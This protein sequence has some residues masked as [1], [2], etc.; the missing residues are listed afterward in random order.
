MTNLHNSS[1]RLLVLLALLN[2]NRAEAWTSNLW[3]PAHLRQPRSEGQNL[4]PDFSFAGYH[5]GG[6]PLPDARVYKR[7]GPISGDNAGQIQAALDQLADQPIGKD[8]YRGTVELAPGRYKVRR[9]LVINASGIILAGSSIN[10]M[11]RTVLERKGKSTGPVI[12][13]G[14]PPESESSDPSEA[15]NNSV[16]EMTTEED[17]STVQE[18]TFLR[19]PKFDI[20]TQDRDRAKLDDKNLVVK[21]PRLS[22]TTPVVSAGSLSFDVDYP[23]SLHVGE[24]VLIFHPSTDAWLSLIENGGTRSYTGWTPG[25]A[26]IYYH[27]EVVAINGTQIT[28]DAPIYSRLD[29]KIAAST[30]R[31]DRMQI[32][33]VGVRDLDIE[34]SAPMAE[35]EKRADTGIRFCAVKDSWA[36]G[37]VVRNFAFS[38]IELVGSSLRCTVKD[39]S[40]VASIPSLNSEEVF[41]FRV[42]QA[43]LI[44]FQHCRTVSVP[45]AFACLGGAEDSGIAI[46][47]STVEGETKILG[48]GLGNW[49]HDLLFDNVH[50][51]QAGSEMKL[52]F[53]D[54]GS[55]RDMAGWG[56]AN[57]VAWNCDLGDGTIILQRPPTADNYAIG[58][59]GNVSGHGL[60][61]A[62]IGY[63]EGSN[64]RGLMPISL[65]EA[66]L[67][68]RKKR[69][70]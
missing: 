54:Y 38:G 27:R 1:L 51:R 34:I 20:P 65:Y 25:R 62:E 23:E 69:H 22:I 41:G 60:V 2:V 66:Q 36:E 57:S 29:R 70:F 11:Q 16:I 64:R 59:Q 42:N 12:R 13:I 47:D 67:E 8:G 63:V 48:A 6:V 18:K 55:T 53:M 24:P 46:V 68:A 56:T 10:N 44:L 58:C 14:D 61:E 17:A 49:T 15:P 37:V 43:Q 4:L 45:Y 52:E 39:C 3:P 35:G 33:H 40:A 26:N 19:A 30:I 7:L 5:G 9:P 28:V 31:E 50:S 32:S 21:S